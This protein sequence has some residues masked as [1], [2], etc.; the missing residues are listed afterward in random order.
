[1]SAIITNQFRKNSRELFINDIGDSTT[2]DYFIGIGKTE[3]WPTIN[4]VDEDNINYT[5][6]LPTNTLIEKEDTLKNLISL[7]KVQETFSVIPRNEW[8]S[9]R[10]YKVYDPYDPN[11]FNFET[12]GATAYYPCYMTHNDKVFVCLSNNDNQVS[13]TNVTATTYSSPSILSDSYVW[14][15][16]CDLSATSNFNTDQFVDIPADLTVNTTPANNAINATGGRVYGFK[17]IDG[18]SNIVGDEDILLVGKDS[19]GAVIADNAIRT[20]SSD[21]G[22][23]SVTIS[24]NSITKIEIT[25]GTGFKS[26]YVDASVIVDGIETNIRP[27]VAPINGFGFSPR[28]DLPSF[29]AGLFG[30]FSGNISG[31]APINVGFR[32]V[33]LVKGP[34]RTD[35]D[36]PANASLNVFDTLQYLEFSGVNG[37]PSDAGTIITHTTHGQKAFL[38]Y[39]D[40]TTNRVYYHQ[41]SSEE[42]NE[43]PFDAGA[44]TFTIP[45]GSATSSFQI[46][47]LGQG[48]YNPG[49]GEALFLENRKAI[50][51]NSNQQEDIKLVIQ[52]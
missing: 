17:V 48:E 27:L 14:A 21:G 41:N 25:G 10:I 9:G 49:T 32:Q 36:T 23:F 1:M 28:S 24:N 19:S 4:G 15:Y 35:N 26:G 39:V 33:S 29:Y 18:G 7:L 30:Q 13:T 46:S 42:I 11:I 52:F 37:I 31:E 43:K 12:I 40:A 3:P 16:V 45:G 44:V 38:D 8:R 6:P 34:T 50:L 2:D 22:G 47:T 20:G 51:R 5:V